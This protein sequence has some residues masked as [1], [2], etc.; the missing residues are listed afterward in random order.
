MNIFHSI[1]ELS[2]LSKP[3]ILVGGTFDGIHVGHQ[4]LIQRAQQ[5]ALRHNSDLVVM[6]FD[7]HPSFL[8]RPNQAPHFLTTIAQKIKILKQLHVEKMLLLP[9]NEAL[10]ATSAEEFIEQL[11]WAGPPLKAI[12]L[13]ETWSF[14]QGGKGNSALLRQK[15]EELHFEVITIGALYVQGAPVSSTRIRQAVASG[16]FE[17]AMACLG[18][19]YALS[20]LVVPGAGR[21]KSLGFPTANLE[22]GKAQLP[23]YGV[24][25]VR[26]EI[27]GI[28]YSGIANIGIR[29]SLKVSSPVPV[30]EVHLFDKSDDLYGKEVTIKLIT[31]L[32]AEKKFATLQELQRQIL[33]DVEDARHQLKVGVPLRS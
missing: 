14:G 30:V 7:Q 26:A 20:G 28:F 15:G 27:E 1:A 33:V 18:R 13:G 10:A 19:D 23:P 12:C 24:Y 2:S 31:F 3:V 21:G 9:F 17:E 22:V 8:L 29:P 11:A 6:T 32:R 4:A 5:E 16:N 25:I